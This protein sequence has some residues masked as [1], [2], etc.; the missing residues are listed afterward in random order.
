MAA[1]LLLSVFLTACQTSETLGTAAGDAKS[2]MVGGRKPHFS[3]LKPFKDSLF[4][5]RAAIS[6]RDNGEY[7]VVPYDEKLDINRRDEMPVRKVKP[8]YTRRLSANRIKDTVYAAPGGPQPLW[9]AGNSGA[10][11]AMTV[12]Y[13]HGKGG[14]RDWGFEDETFGGNFNRAKN[15]LAEAGGAWLSPDFTDFEA[16]GAADIAAL[17]RE[18]KPLTRGKLV[19]ACGS[20]GTK[21]CWRLVLDPQ[22]SG[23]IGGLVLLGGF[24]EPRFPAGDR[25]IPVYIAHGSRDSVYAASAMEEMYGRLKSAGQ[26]VR[27]TVFDTGNHGTPVRMIDWRMAL[28]WI[29]SN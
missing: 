20:M 23:M 22:L 7:L 28:N 24:P 21:L 14:N 8:Q 19:L 6:S 26:P 12:I 15:L 17:I 11:A 9:I 27:M 18:R 5:Y 25:H 4:G 10:D 2:H 16:A 29:A 13:L 3:P 1:L